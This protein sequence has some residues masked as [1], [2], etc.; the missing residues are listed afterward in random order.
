MRI[1]LVVYFILMG[2]LSLKYP[3]KMTLLGVKWKYDNP[4][5]SELSIMITIIVSVISIILGTVFLISF[6]L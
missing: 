6:L 4:E 2:L 5:P 3:K 1:L